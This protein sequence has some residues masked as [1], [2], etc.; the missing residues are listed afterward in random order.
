MGAN[1]QVQVAH[2]PAVRLERSPELSVFPSGCGIP[3]QNRNPGQEFIYDLF[4]PAGVRTPC[5][6]IAQLAFIDG[7]NPVALSALL[8]GDG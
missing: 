4:E 3:G 1:H 2:G 5:H 6:A 8:R 7:R